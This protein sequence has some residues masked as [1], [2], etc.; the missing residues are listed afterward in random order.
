M[1]RWLFFECSSWWK[2]SPFI[3]PPGGGLSVYAQFGSAGTT[4]LHQVRSWRPLSLLGLGTYFLLPFPLG[5]GLDTEVTEQRP[6]Q[7]EVPTACSAGEDLCP[8]PTPGRRAYG[9]RDGCPLML[10]LWGSNNEKGSLWGLGSI[11]WWVP[12]PAEK[13]SHGL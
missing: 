6:V 11:I 10:N 7:A 1:K 12:G 4:V 8:P 9:G 2:T 3:G 5:L 13:H